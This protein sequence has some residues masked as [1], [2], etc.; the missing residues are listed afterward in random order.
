MRYRVREEVEVVKA[1]IDE[2]HSYGFNAV[3]CSVHCRNEAEVK[4]VFAILEHTQKWKIGELQLLG[5][6][7]R[8]RGLESF[9]QNALQSSEGRKSGQV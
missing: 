9:K 7:C 2:L 4:T 5:H 8:S 1:S 3:A 6:I